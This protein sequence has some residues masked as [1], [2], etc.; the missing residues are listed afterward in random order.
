MTRRTAKIFERG[1]AERELRTARRWLRALAS[2]V[3]FSIRRLDEE[4]QNPATLERGKRIATICNDLQ[5][6][7]DMAT[8]FG[9]PSRRI[10]KRSK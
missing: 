3:A 8:R 4:M 6:S 7:H 2:T 5:L 9:L 10:R 1:E